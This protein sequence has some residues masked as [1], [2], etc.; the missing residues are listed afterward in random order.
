MDPPDTLL[1]RLKKTLL[2]LPVIVALIADE[3]LDWISL[4]KNPRRFMGSLQNPSILDG[5]VWALMPIVWQ[6]FIS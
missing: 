2:E 6:L 4:V 3:A 5:L 1:T